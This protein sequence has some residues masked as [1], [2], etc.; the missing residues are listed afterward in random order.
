MIICISSCSVLSALAL[1]VLACAGLVFQPPFQL[2]GA[3]EAASG[4]G[5]SQ[6]CSPCATCLKPLEPPLK[7][8]LV[9]VRHDLSSP[10]RIKCLGRGKAEPSASSWSFQ[11]HFCTNLDTDCFARLWDAEFQA[12]GEKVPGHRVAVLPPSRNHVPSRCPGTCQGDVG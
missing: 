5:L 8:Y 2:S 12:R 1:G 6:H 11:E 3:A 10:Y 9:S 4:R 7:S